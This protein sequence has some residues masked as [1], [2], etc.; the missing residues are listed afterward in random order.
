MNIS[1]VSIAPA[2]PC[3]YLSPRIHGF[4]QW[5]KHDESEWYWSHLDPAVVCEK[6]PYY[7][8]PPVVAIEAKP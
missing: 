8:A 1:P 7:E 5:C 6:C 3:L 4:R 2:P